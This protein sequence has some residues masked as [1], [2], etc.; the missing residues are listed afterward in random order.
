MSDPSLS[1][2]I[3]V[4][5]DDVNVREQV[6]LALGKRLRPE[7]PGA[8]LHRRREHTSGDPPLDAAPKSGFRASFPLLDTQPVGHYH[9]NDSDDD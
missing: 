5:C 2:R 9:D 4:Y 6:K 3:L 7:L 1:L 8:H